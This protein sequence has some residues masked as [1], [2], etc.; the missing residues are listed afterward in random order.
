MQPVQNRLERTP[1]VTPPETP[2][3]EALLVLDGAGWRD[4]LYD[5]PAAPL[6]DLEAFDE[7]LFRFEGL[8]RAVAF[9]MREMERRS[10]DV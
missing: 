2:S 7:I 6:P 5:E 9:L 8:Q 1:V 3:P 10:D 4:F